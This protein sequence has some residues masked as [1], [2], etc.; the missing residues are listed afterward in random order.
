MFFSVLFC[1]VLFLLIVHV[2]SYWIFIV[3]VVYYT[4][5]NVCSVHGMQNAKQ[6]S[7]IL[8]TMQAASQ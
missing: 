1:F 7:S 5:V 4:R 8:T 3:V 2:F 6:C